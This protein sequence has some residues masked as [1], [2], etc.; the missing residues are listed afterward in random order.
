MA[1]IPE[2]F[3]ALI[4]ITGI[5]MIFQGRYLKKKD[6]SLLVN[7]YEISFYYALTY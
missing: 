6:T 1:R 5:I 4:A 3:W 7:T 2:G